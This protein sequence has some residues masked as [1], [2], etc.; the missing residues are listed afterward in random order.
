MKE[1]P[2]PSNSSILASGHRL[3]LLLH[4]RAAANQA[5]MMNSREVLKVERNSVDLHSV[6]CISLQLKRVRWVELR[7][8]H[9]DWDVDGRYV[10]FGKQ[11]GMA[12]DDTVDDAVSF[13]SQAKDR[14]ASVAVPYAADFAVLRAEFL[15]AGE[16]LWLPLFAAM[17]SKEACEVEFGPG[18]SFQSVGGEALT[19]KTVRLISRPDEIA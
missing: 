13:G 17:S 7:G 1:L 4:F 6:E 5:S 11:T 10:V 12:S 15:G 8:L 19:G 9:L 18:F 16:D 3:S 2:Q 14:P